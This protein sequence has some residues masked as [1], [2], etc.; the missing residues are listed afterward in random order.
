MIHL[1]PIDEKIFNY[2]LNEINLAFPF[3]RKPKYDNKYYLEKIIYMLKSGCT[4]REAN[5]GSVKNH[6]SSIYKKYNQWVTSGFF[7]D[8]F[9]KLVGKYKKKRRKKL[10]KN[11]HKSSLLTLFVDSS[12]I[13][14]KNGSELLGRT[15]QDKRKKGN[16]IT[17]ICD[18]E[19]FPLIIDISAANVHDSKILTS[20]KPI[21]KSLFDLHKDL[22]LTK[23]NLAG[24]MGYIINDNKKKLLFKNKIKIIHPYR[25]NQGRK[26][27]K[28]DRKILKERHKVENLFA[29][30]KQF[31]KIQLR[32]DSKIKNYEA[33]VKLALTFI[34][35]R[36]LFRDT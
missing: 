19:K 29:S 18:Q 31:K 10:K 32:Y 15:Y 34:G 9:S 28:S 1:N 21:K 2:V 13:R 7:D 12:N 23:I 20:S 26:N 6:Y 11:L 30:L 16:K 22:K 3:K 35:L 17:V 27:S 4:Y 36:I 24:D 5:H 33:F 8:L 25:K 14:N